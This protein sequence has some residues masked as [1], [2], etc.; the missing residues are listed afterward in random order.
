MFNAK[1]QLVCFGPARLVLL[2]VPSTDG[3]LGTGIDRGEGEV[4]QV[5][6]PSEEHHVSYAETLIKIMKSKKRK[7]SSALSDINY[8][9]DYE[10]NDDDYEGNDD[11]DGD[12]D[13]DGDEDQT[14]DGQEFSESKVNFS[15]SLADSTATAAA[16][17][18]W[19][20]A[21]DKSDDTDVDA[22]VDVDADDYQFT[23]DSAEVTDD[24]PFADKQRLATVASSSSSSG[25]RKDSAIEKFSAARTTDE[26]SSSNN[27]N[28]SAA[29]MGISLT[30]KQTDESESTDVSLI[31]SHLPNSHR[32]RRR[33]THETPNREH[34]TLRLYVIAFQL[35]LALLHGYVALPIS[36]IK[37]SN[38]NGTRRTLS[39]DEA[40][41]RARCCTSNADIACQLSPADVGLGQYWR[42]LAVVLEML[43]ITDSGALIDWSSSL[44]GS[45]LLQLVLHMRE[46]GDVQ[47][48]AVTI[49]TFGGADVLMDLLL[50]TCNDGQSKHLDRLQLGTE[51]NYVLYYYSDLLHRWGEHM[52]AVEVLAVQPGDDDHNVYKYLY[53]Y[54][55]ICM[56]VVGFEVHQ[57]RQ[58][59]DT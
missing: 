27:N 49:C 43:T 9:D 1:G 54:L 25:E 19:D 24:S 12:D 17:V 38:V 45:L 10:G 37:S 40:H 11:R 48:Y 26:F 52:H 57:L 59:Q 36:K 16:I 18:S 21:I 28:H 29:A 58:H 3:G 55:Y 20:S 6:I 47:T 42:L 2:T 13:C 4:E 8:D 56:Y 22:D 14:D 7:N 41:S 35:E 44:G 33:T 5:L 23:F 53:A 15:V 51:M 31:Y 46:V 32:N 30:R 50:G 34:V 39:A